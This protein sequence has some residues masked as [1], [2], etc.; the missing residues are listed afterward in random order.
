[1]ALRSSQLRYFVAVADEGHIAG[2]AAKLHVA[3]S[4]VT[5]AIASLESELGF[6]GARATRPGH[7]ADPSR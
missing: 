7:E 1:M 3:P 5:Q 2:A 4:T 6:T